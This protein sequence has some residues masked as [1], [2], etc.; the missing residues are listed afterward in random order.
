MVLHRW[1][2]SANY[3]VVVGTSDAWTLGVPV[4][5]QGDFET[6]VNQLVRGLGSDGQA[7]PVRIYSNRVVR[8]GGL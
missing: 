5:L 3:R 1:A 7:P 4:H 8:L 2:K 6:A